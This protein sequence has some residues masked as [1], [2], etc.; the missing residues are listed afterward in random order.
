M[1]YPSFTMGVSFIQ[2][3]SEN[4]SYNGSYIYIS[5]ISYIRIV[6]QFRRYITLEAMMHIRGVLEG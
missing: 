1:I 3:Y 4:G 2:P 5:Y 6:D